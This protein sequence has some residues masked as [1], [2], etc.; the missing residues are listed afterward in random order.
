[1]LSATTRSTRAQEHVQQEC[2][3]TFNKS[4]TTRS[5]RVQQHVQQERKSMRSHVFRIQPQRH[6]AGGGYGAEGNPWGSSEEME[7]ECVAGL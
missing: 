2:N 4:A 5:T 3:N 7:C 1:M 6:G